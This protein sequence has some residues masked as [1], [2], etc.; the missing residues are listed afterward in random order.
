MIKD[1]VQ[2]KNTNL[3]GNTFLFSHISI[4]WFV[5][6][7]SRQDT[8]T[9]VVSISCSQFQWVAHRVLWNFTKYRVD[10]PVGMLGFPGY[11]NICWVV[12]AGVEVTHLVVRVVGHGVNTVIFQGSATV[13]DIW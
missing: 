1:L 11:F 10:W 5:I 8:S 9:L 3:Q 2:Y 7:L 12:V 4:L 13:K 6:V